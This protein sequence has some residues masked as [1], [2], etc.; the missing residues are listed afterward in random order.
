MLA[1][2]KL[3]EPV[4]S[5]VFF[6]ITVAIV[7]NGADSVL[8]GDCLDVGWLEVIEEVSA[9]N[10]RSQYHDW[11]AGSLTISYMAS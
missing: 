6:R 7:A 10:P 1:S 8:L 2:R 4:R 11:R 3:D 5:L 9:A